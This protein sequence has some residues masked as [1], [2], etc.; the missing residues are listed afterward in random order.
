MEILS[1]ENAWNPFTSQVTKGAGSKV[2]QL[3]VAGKF[4]RNVALAGESLNP[5]CAEQPGGE[6]AE[7]NS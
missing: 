1:P 6:G 2:V 7:L 4:T 3:R 5:C